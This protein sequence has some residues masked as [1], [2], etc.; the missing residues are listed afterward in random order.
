MVSHIC[1]TDRFLSVLCHQKRIKPAK[2]V[3]K[4]VP[5]ELAIFCAKHADLLLK[6]HLGSLYTNYGEQF[7]KAEGQEQCPHAGPYSIKSYLLE[8]MKE[9]TWGG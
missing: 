6:Q 2:A 3:Y 7:Q 5:W 8:L 9:N 4:S 1:S